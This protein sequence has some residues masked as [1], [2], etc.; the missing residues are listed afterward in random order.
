MAFPATLIISSQRMIF[1]SFFQYSGIRQRSYDGAKFS[2]FKIAFFQTPDILFESFGK[3]NLA[4]LDPQVLQSIINRIK[5]F[6]F[7]R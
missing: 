7:R 2:S 1:V 4:H 3:D 5:I 6:T